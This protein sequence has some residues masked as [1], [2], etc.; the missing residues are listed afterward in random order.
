MSITIS[1]RIFTLFSYYGDIRP[2]IAAHCWRPRVKR[3][4]LLIALIHHPFYNMAKEKK[5]LKFNLIQFNLI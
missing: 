2:I 1:N 4:R 3:H 5:I